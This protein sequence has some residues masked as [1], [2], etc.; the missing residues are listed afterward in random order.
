MP[1]YEYK[2]PVCGH[3]F[4]VLTSISKRDEAKCE[5]CGAKVAR[6]Y[7]GK[8]AFG[9]GVNSAGGGCGGNCAGCSGCGG[10]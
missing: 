6:V 1:I 2:C 7:E 9:A 10:N 8:C 5:K 4:E 3:K